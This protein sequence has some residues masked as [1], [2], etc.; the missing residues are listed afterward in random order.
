M[1]ASLSRP[2]KFQS[3]EVEGMF[4]KAFVDPYLGYRLGTKINVSMRPGDPGSGSD[5]AEV[6]WF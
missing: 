2:Q 1:P 4:G 6:C 3:A 5:D